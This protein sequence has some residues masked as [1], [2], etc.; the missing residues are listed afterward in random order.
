MYSMNFPKSYYISSVS[1]HAKKPARMFHYTH[2][3]H[4]LNA[5]SAADAYRFNNV[6]SINRSNTVRALL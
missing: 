6:N 5:A 1:H 3:S 2:S 4:S